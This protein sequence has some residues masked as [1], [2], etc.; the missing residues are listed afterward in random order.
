MWQRRIVDRKTAARYWVWWNIKITLASKTVKLLKFPKFREMVQQYR[1]RENASIYC[2]ASNHVNMRQVSYCIT[3]RT[4]HQF[5][6]FPL[7]RPIIGT[8]ELGLLTATRLAESQEWQSFTAI[9]LRI[10]EISLPYPRKPLN[11]TLLRPVSILLLHLPKRRETDFYFE[12]LVF[13]KLSVKILDL[14][15]NIRKLTISKLRNS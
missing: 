2:V 12:L 7:S 14:K 6:D 5:L 3:A 9:L 8:L 4:S 13:V 1:C 15:I 11:L 10:L